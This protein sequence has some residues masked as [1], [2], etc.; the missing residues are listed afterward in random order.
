MKILS[1]F[2]RREARKNR[3]IFLIVKTLLM[4]LALAGVAQAQSTIHVSGNLQTLGVQNVNANGT[5][6]RFTLR[7]FGSQIPTVPGTTSI[8]WADQD[9]LPDVNGNISGLLY[10]NGSITQ[11]P[12]T[13]YHVCIWYRSQLFRCNDYL[14]NGD[15]NLD[16]AIPISTA[17]PAGLNQLLIQCALPFV[18]STPATTWTVVHGLGDTNIVY[19]MW[20][21]AGVQFWP[22]QAVKTDINTLTLN[23]VTPQTGTVTVCHGVAISIATNQPNA[24]LQNPVAPQSVNSFL[25]TINAPFT[26]TGVTTL[27]NGFTTGVWTHSSLHTFNGGITSAGPNTF[28]GGGTT[29][30]AW[31]HSGVHTFSVAPVFSASPGFSIN[32][33]LVPNLNAS[34]LLGNTWAIPQAIGSTTPAGGTFT[35]LTANTQLVINGGTPLTTTNQT[36]TGSIAMGNSPTIATPTIN[37]ASSGTG[38]QGTDTK[39]LTSGTISGTGNNICSDANGGATTSG[40]NT[41][42]IR[43]ASAAGCTTGSTSFSPCD[44]TLTWSGGGFA[45]TGYFPVCKG[46]DTSIQA[47]GGDGS[48]G[49]VPILN[50]RSFTATQIVVVTQTVAARVATYGTIYCVGVHP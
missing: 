34:L 36:G 7:N 17:S 20:T 29:S 5:F 40:C 15:F 25:L 42:V 3:L 11:P 22:D 44:N 21:L 23:F 19:D 49:H 35:N 32:S 2:Q 13:F 27:A 43:T 41:N 6:V 8:A 10:T 39:L 14:I 28:N 47:S 33:T 16:N 38:V 12:G 24:V 9:F 1:I 46:L 50:I 37:G 45:D 26:V 18:Q 31:T 48:S 4:V 30:G